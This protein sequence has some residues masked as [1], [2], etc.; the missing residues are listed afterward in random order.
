MRGAYIDN[1]DIFRVM[2]GATGVVPEPASVV[3]LA[4][5]LIG[6]AGLFAR[7]SR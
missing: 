1:T 7:R 2:T 4:T 3:A 5:G 6:F